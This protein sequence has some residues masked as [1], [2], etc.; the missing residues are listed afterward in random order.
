LD[1]EEDILKSEETK[2][3]NYSGHRLIGSLWAR[4]DLIP[5]TEFYKLIRLS[6]FFFKY[7]VWHPS[8]FEL[9]FFILIMHSIGWESFSCTVAL[10]CLIFGSLNC[11]FFQRLGFFVSCLVCPLSWET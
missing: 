8:Q 6:E 5:L 11:N 7:L 1:I 9:S 2:L 4:S 10:H 3:W